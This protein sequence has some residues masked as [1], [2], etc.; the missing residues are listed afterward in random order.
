MSLLMRLSS[1]HIGIILALVAFRGFCGGGVTAQTKQPGAPTAS[2]S[3]GSISGRVIFPDGSFLT[4]S[5]RITLQTIRGVS[6]SVFTDPQGQFQF[7]DL[8]AGSYQVVIEGD[9][10]RFETTTQKVEVV[11]GYPSI[12]TIVLKEKDPSNESK[13][14]ARTVSLGELDA[15][16]PSKARK[17]F[18]HANKAGKEGK[19]EEAIAFLRKAIA[20]YP[21]YLVAH[22]DLGAQLLELGRLDE[23][24]EELRAALNIDRAAFNPT[25]NLGIVLVKKHEF[26]QARELLD[27]A[28]SLNSESPAARLYA[29]LAL[30][31]TSD[32]ARAE[33][34]LMAAYHLGG[35]QYA[36]ALFHLGQL[37]LDKGDRSLAREYFQRYLREAPKANNLDQVRKLIAMLD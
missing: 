19:L 27:K 4:E 23:A 32:L 35:S 13:M 11:R 17:E 15:R 12:L 10:D 30:L 2:T 21:A 22:N 1:R 8:S 9:R 6:A 31:A 25:L 29:G 24:E 20:L 14:I 7:G 28:V 36:E 16:V 34:E 5:K 26:E 3:S 33:K 37:Y 18:E